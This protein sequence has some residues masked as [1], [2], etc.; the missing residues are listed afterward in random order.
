MSE[1]AD[2]MHSLLDR[3]ISTESADEFGHRH[4]AKALQSLIELPNKP[5]YSIGLLGKWGTGKSSIKELYRA[6]LEDDAARSKA[7]KPITFNAWRHGGEDIKRAL[8][9]HVFMELNGN[10]DELLDALSRHVQTVIPQHKSF[11]M[12][13]R[14]VA[15][16]IPIALSLLIIAIL[17]SASATWYLKWLLNLSEKPTLTLIAG[18]MG[19]AIT[20]L[21]GKLLEIGN[22]TNITRIEPPSST[23][24]DYERF[25]LKQMHTFKDANGAD[26]TRLVVFVDDLDRLGP[27]EMVRG[28]DAIRTFME[29]PTNR[30]PAGLGVVFV[31]SCDEE[32]VAKVL[33]DR[34]C[35]PGASLPG[36]VS[37]LGD[38]H[39]FLDRIFQFRLD[40]PPFPKRDMRT[41]AK[42][43]LCQDLPEIAAELNKR[44]VLEE[45]VSRLIHV[46]VQS[47]RNAVQL[48]NMFA[49]CWWLAKTRE[50]DG[51]GTERTGGLRQGAVT[52]HPITLAVV[53]VLRVDFPDFYEDLLQEPELVDSF[54]KVCI[55]GGAFGEQAESV[56]RILRKYF[57]PET[58]DLT[59]ED[60]RPLLRYINSLQELVWPS[61]KM[62]LLLLSQDPLTRKVGDRGPR[63]NDALVSADHREVLRIL[64]H[65]K[66]AKP[67]SQDDI[68][69]LHEVM[70]DFIEDE[71]IDRRRNADVAIAALLDRLP[72]KH[73]DKLLIR[74]IRRLIQYPE[75][76]WRLG[77]VKIGHVLSRG[78]TGD[79]RELARIL[80]D[81]VLKTEGEIGFRRTVENALTLDEAISVARETC[82]IVLEVRAK[83]G[84]D[85]QSETALLNWLEKRHVMVGGEEGHLQIQDL[86]QWM[87]EY[88][89]GLL[90]PMG[91]SYTRSLLEE[92]DAGHPV[93]NDAIDRARCVFEM[94]R[95]GDAFEQAELWAQL[96]RYVAVVQPQAVTLAHECASKNVGNADEKTISAFTKSFADRIARHAVKNQKRYAIDDLTQGHTLLNLIRQRPESLDEECR[97]AL[98]PLAKSWGTTA[99]KA[100]MAIGILDVLCELDKRSSQIISDWIER[101][102]N[103]LPEPC[104]DWLSQHFTDK[105]TN[106]QRTGITDQMRVLCGRDDIS[107]DEGKRYCRILKTMSPE[108]IK[109]KPMQDHL[110]FLLDQ[111]GERCISLDGFFYRVFEAVPP[112]LSSIPSTIVGPML[113]K[114]FDGLIN[115]HVA[116]GWAHYW[117]VSYWPLPS[118]KLQPYNPQH[119]FEQGPVV[120]GQFPADKWD[121][122]VHIVTS[123][124]KMMERGV[125][126]NENAGSLV[127]AAC[128]LWP[129]KQ[130]KALNTITGQ[131]VSPDVRKIAGLMNGIDFTNEEQ[132][133]R[134]CEAWRHFAGLITEDE[135]RLVA[136]SILQS[137]PLGTERDPDLAL[138]VWVDENQVHQSILLDGLLRDLD[139]ND[140]QRQ[141]VWL[142]TERLAPHVGLSVFITVLPGLLGLQDIPNTTKAVIEAQTTLTRLC[143][144]DRDRIKLGTALLDAFLRTSSLDLKNKLALWIKEAKAASSLNQMQKLGNPTKDDIQILKSYFPGSRALKKYKNI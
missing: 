109:S 6:C 129:Y 26:C 47:P 117:M 9:R 16:R 142:Q 4:F 35:K 144:N 138:Q 23:A 50:R 126:S 41:Y 70:E 106:S 91:A 90:L 38:A 141:R 124:E 143:V 140:D 89:D 110:A 27:E 42:K 43:R 63:L 29:I 68:D 96:C 71:S 130:E 12:V 101:L 13:L 134:L 57:N 64:G 40:I 122:A 18:A 98:I 22:S 33:S 102:L 61:S 103:D 14:D 97:Q 86:E 99:E 121:W 88:E 58:N 46:G 100:N 78:H 118:D 128:L 20:F 49:Q 107:K 87:S 30:I 8:L 75:L 51:S 115:E 112:L 32:R 79:R 55:R 76:R 85:N 77:I 19:V 81:S 83:D 65:D 114:V 1:D 116:Y 119:I 92:L 54:T 39:R 84:L 37:T 67:L 2:L 72:E 131:D 135:S 132:R 24:E 5:P 108:S 60:Y 10:E 120:L 104:L 52:S 25:L 113:Q 62:P 133:D 31:I 69:Q 95:G 7:I 53:C 34:D 3:E 123:M 48:L 66:D 45:V 17:V 136:K 21:I 111:I 15:L 11:R 93:E 36:T 94:L 139:L 56:Q 125:V 59:N 80:V 137:A 44:G 74:L 28:L 82:S 73:S 105:L 127:E